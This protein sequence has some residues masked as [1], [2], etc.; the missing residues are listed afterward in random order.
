MN[1]LSQ[2]IFQARKNQGI[3][4][5][6]LAEKSK[7]N[8]RT[9]Q[10]IEKGETTPYGDTLK[11]ISD[12]PNIPIEDLVNYGFVED[13]AY[14]KAMHFSTLVFVVLP[15]GNIILPVILWL[16]KKNQ[17]KDLSYYAKKLI[18]FEITWSICIFL[19]VTII[20]ALFFAG[21][22]INLPEEQGFPK[23]TMM[24]LPLLFLLFSFLN[25]IY[26]I[27]VGILIKDSRHN[28]FPIAIPFLR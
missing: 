10:R 15:L 1:Q 2:Q 24:V 14:I 11:K 25:F 7:I 4:Q 3:S 23:F 22:K 18:N 21:V 12:A 20:V 6:Q 27:I 9:L 5:E 17:I 16:V 19:P 26:L 8:L 28:Y 13:Y